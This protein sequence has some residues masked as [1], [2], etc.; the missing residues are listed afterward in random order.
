MQIQQYKHWYYYRPNGTTS[1]ESE[2]LITFF[3]PFFQLVSMFLVNMLGNFNLFLPVVP[4]WNIPTILYRARDMSSWYHTYLLLFC[5]RLCALLSITGNIFKSAPYWLFI[6]ISDQKCHS[7]VKCL[8]QYLW[9]LMY[10]MHWY[11]P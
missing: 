2:A 1:L 10:H 9:F 7:M 5:R 3:L 11:T 6:L 8:V 4:N